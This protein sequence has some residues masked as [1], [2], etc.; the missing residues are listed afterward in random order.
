[1]DQSQTACKSNSG[2]QHADRESSR[3]R[4]AEGSWS[5]AS[6]NRLLAAQIR[7][8]V[9][10][11]LF[12]GTNRGLLDLVRKIE[13]L[14]LGR[15]LK[16]GKLREARAL[17]VKTAHSM[18]I[19]SELLAELRLLALTDDL[20]GLYNRRGFLILALQQI[21]VSRRNGQPMLLF[22]I[23]VDH[24]KAANDRFGHDEGDA[25]LLRCAEVLNDTFRESD[26]VAR[27][28][29]D[30]FAVLAVEGA[31]RTSAAITSRLEKA[32][33]SVN[34]QSSLA[35]LSLSVGTARFDPQ[36]PVVLAELLTEADCNMYR[37]KRERNGADFTPL[38]SCD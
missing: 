21:K 34:Q 27:L 19:Q 3:N 5:V 33:Q 25:L 38:S 26:L 2:S 22:L 4:G 18:A 32:I 17:L 8:G 6:A 15:E 35:S 29:G 14:P 1:M 31:G 30:E 13:T 37:H 11:A 12:D 23:D 20:T 24:L 36:V 10:P 9:P 16:A 28:G 7:D